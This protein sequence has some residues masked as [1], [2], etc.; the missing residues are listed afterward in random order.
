MIENLS[1]FIIHLIQTT[2]YA[3]IFVLMLLESALVPVPSEITMPFA[4]F[5]VQRGELNFVL[6]VLTG[7]FANLV[8]SIAAY[9]LGFYLEETVVLKFIERYGKFFLLSKHD[10]EKSTRW[11]RKYGDAVAFFSRVLPAIRT[12]IS[13]PAGLAEMNVWKF[14]IYSFLGSVIWSGLL[15]YIG[16]YFGSNWHALEPSFKQ[17]QLG[18]G[19]IFLLLLAWFLKRKLKTS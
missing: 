13:L 15:T 3:G 16:V 9:Y 11:L 1:A 14:S 18:I 5:L 2:G 12:F 4:G 7:A 8:G 10:Y 6:V 17:F 19:I